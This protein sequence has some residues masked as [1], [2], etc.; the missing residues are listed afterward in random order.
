MLSQAVLLLALLASA[1]ATG[2]PDPSVQLE[3]PLLTQAMQREQFQPLAGDNSAFKFSF[4][5]QV[6]SCVAG[7]VRRAGSAGRADDGHARRATRWTTQQ[8]SRSR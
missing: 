5:K 8:A 4:A 1:S 3:T 2:Y 7:G 6:C